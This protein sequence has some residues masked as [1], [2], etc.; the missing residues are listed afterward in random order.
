MAKSND[1]APAIFNQIVSGTEIT[2]DIKADGDLRIDGVLN[3]NLLTKGKL[4]IGTTGIITGEI[5]CKNA[6]VE[7]KIEGQIAVTDLLTLKNTALINGDIT[8]SKLAIQPGAKFTG[9]CNMNGA[10]KLYEAPTGKENGK[11]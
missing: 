8:T 4:V 2:G 1:V 9:N 6:D 10:N 5:R 11:A 3:G 7:G